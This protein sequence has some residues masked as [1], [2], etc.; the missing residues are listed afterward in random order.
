MF[1]A[2]L[3]YS[4]VPAH[5]RALGSLTGVVT[6]ATGALV[7]SFDVEV[8]HISHRSISAATTSA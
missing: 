7:Q 4:A 8:I 1:A 5:A 3:L 6:D 2:M